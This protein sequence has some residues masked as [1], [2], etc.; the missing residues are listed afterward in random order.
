MS[1]SDQ[2]RLCGCNFKV[3]FGNLSQTSYISS[4]NLF[5]LSQRKDCIR[6]KFE[7][8]INLPESWTRGG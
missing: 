5:N 3:K 4:E 8:K 2:F 1:P 7:N 6:D